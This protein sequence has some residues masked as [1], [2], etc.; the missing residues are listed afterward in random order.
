MRRLAFVFLGIVALATAT[1]DGQGFCEEEIELDPQTLSC[2]VQGPDLP[3][4]AERLIP[5]SHYERYA[6]LV[7]EHRLDGTASYYAQKFEGRK[8][9]NGEIFRHRRYTGAH[10]TLPLGCLVEVRAVATGKKL[11][12]RINDRGPYKGGFVVDLSKAAARVLGVD[13]ARDRRVEIRVLAL[14]G[15]TPPPEFPD[16]SQQV[17][18]GN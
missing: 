5:P 6:H 2:Y 8:T 18:S 1:A 15:E 11:R 12:I 9:A 17:A 7:D 16:V 14:P 10:R 13:R 3:S 4:P